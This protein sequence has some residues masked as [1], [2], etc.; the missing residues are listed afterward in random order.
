VSDDDIARCT[1]GGDVDILVTHDA[2]AGW[3]IPGLRPDH[4]APR[5]WQPE[6]PACRAH[7]DRLAEVLAAT[8]PALV[9][10]GHY[11]VGYRL[12]VQTE[13]GDIHVVGLSHDG[14]TR[15]LALL[16]CEGA[17]WRLEVLGP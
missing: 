3:P 10:H 11:H 17:R 8:R 1:E 16:D 13:W 12:D 14:T 9:V 6:L 4:E 15:S 5:L 2:P 7:R